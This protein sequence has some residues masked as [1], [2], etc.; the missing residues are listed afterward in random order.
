MPAI[1]IPQPVW[2]SGLPAA[3]AHARRDIAR[4]MATHPSQIVRTWTE[5]GTPPAAR[6]KHTKKVL[7]ALPVQ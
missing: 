4:R 2:A 7:D 1:W 5:P 3:I 6:R